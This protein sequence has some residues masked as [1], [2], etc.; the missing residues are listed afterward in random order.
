MFE[1]VREWISVEEYLEME[2]R[3]EE[4]H[5]YF[6]GEIYAMSGASP[7]HN[8]ISGNVLA[9]LWR[10]LR[11]RPCRVYPSDQRVKIPDTGLYTYPDV[12]VICGAPEFDDSKPRSL[13]NPTL[14]VEVLSERTEAYDRGAKFAHYQRLPSLQEYVLVSSHQ[15]R[16]ERFLRQETGAGWLY[17]QCSQPDATLELASIG[18][19]LPLAG[20]YAK[21]QFVE[22][23]P[24]EQRGP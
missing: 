1:R 17:G 8:L 10:Q 7:E 12:T 3:S 16:V 18:C 21:V 15:T 14:I 6:N 2:A 19:T 13:L 5:E 22:P 24:G 20:V 9:E 23:E 11:D 4:K